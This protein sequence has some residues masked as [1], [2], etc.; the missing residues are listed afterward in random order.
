MLPSTLK[1]TNLNA[2]MRPWKTE[3]TNWK[4]EREVVKNQQ[5]EGPRPKSEG[6]MD[7]PSDPSAKIM[8]N[9]KQNGDRFLLYKNSND[10]MM[11]LH[12]NDLTCN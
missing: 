4:K 7:V 1:L 5:S 11:S 2:K 9:F 6:G 12:A 3:L 8:S 10:L